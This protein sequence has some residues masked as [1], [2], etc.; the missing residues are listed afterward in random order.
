MSK[1]VK[2]QNIPIAAKYTFHQERDCCGEGDEDNYLEI[3]THDGGG[4]QY[5]VIKTERW[6]I[7]PGEFPEFINLL[8]KSLKTVRDQF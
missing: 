3:E 2:S 5:L 6:A 4:G 1:E 8:K 7:E